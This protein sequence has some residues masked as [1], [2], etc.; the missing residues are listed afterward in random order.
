MKS[1]IIIGLLQLPSIVCCCG[2]IYLIDQGKAGWGWLLF[3][4]VI[5]GV[6]SKW[7]DT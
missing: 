7:S 3:V 4:A 6:S 5:T 1:I 2:A